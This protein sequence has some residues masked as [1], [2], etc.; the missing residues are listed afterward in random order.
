VCFS[1][2]WV[3][4]LL[5]WIVIICAII[6]LLRLVL[7]WVFSAFG[8]AIPGIIIQAIN[9]FIWA[10]VAILVIIFIFTLISC[11]LSMGGSLSLFPR[12]G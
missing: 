5:I 6:A 7:P 3:E 2:E 8:V 11:L 1:L 9:I 12:H 4:T 10:V